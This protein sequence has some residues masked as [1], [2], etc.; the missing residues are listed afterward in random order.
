[1]T[2]DLSNLLDTNHKNL[3]FLLSKNVNTSILGHIKLAHMIYFIQ[4]Q[5]FYLNKN[6]GYNFDNFSYSFNRWNYGPY[7]QSIDS[8]LTYLEQLKLI[9]VSTTPTSNTSYKQYKLSVLGLKLVNESILE[10]QIKYNLKI[11]AMKLWIDKFSKYS[12]DQV[13]AF[14]YKQAQISLYEMG[15][16]M[17]LHSSLLQDNKQLVLN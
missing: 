2:K 3:L 1:M 13:I 12:Q 16:R 7:T 17:P 10:S 6:N 8:D 9:E 15:D 11:E 4:S 5:I 14:T